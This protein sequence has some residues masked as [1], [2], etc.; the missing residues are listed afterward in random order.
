MVVTHPPTTETL[1][2]TIDKFWEAL[3][4]AW[5]SIR[6]H[7]RETATQRFD[8]SEEQ[9]HVLRH[10]AHGIGSMSELAAA[11]QI[12]LPAVSQSVE[13][14]V[15]KGLLTR[16]QSVDDRRFV[17]LSLTENGSALL[18]AIYSVNRQWMAGKLAGLGEEDLLGLI[19]AMEALHKTFV[20]NPAE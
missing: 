12:S 15:Q 10:V 16:R 2:R 20:H 18:D 14:L 11:K 13:T 5:R 17:Q 9:Y 19:Q 4:P 6:F 7:I 3:L 1:Q 8:I